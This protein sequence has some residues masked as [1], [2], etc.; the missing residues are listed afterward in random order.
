M[1]LKDKNARKLALLAGV[2]V[3]GLSACGSSKKE[4]PSAATESATTSETTVKAGGIEAST[5]TSIDNSEIPAAIEPAESAT[6]TLTDISEN[7]TAIEVYDGKGDVEVILSGKTDLEG[8]KSITVH[9]GG[10]LVF[11]NGERIWTYCDVSENDHLVGNDD[12]CVVK[13]PLEAVGE[14]SLEIMAYGDE[15]YFD[16][17]DGHASGWIVTLA[18]KCYPKLR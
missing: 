16:F 6:L 2:M 9:P 4:T 12:E 3:L 14:A 5:D 11:H 15:D 1:K 17:S 10:E 8:E 7:I 13:I 18:E